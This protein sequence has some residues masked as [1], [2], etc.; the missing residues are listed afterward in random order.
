MDTHYNRPRAIQTTN[1]NTR[2]FIFH[3]ETKP[4][5]LI[6]L[7]EL[8]L[9]STTHFPPTPRFYVLSVLGGPNHM[10]DL[11]DQRRLLICLDSSSTPFHRSYQIFSIGTKNNIDTKTNKITHRCHSNVQRFVTTNRCWTLSINFEPSS[12]IRQCVFQC[13]ISFVN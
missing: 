11:H 2:E 3:I 8:H 4:L 12:A 5:A 10:L 13:F 6:K 7:C 1:D 9:T